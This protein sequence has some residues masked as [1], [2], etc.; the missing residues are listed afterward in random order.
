MAAGVVYGSRYEAYPRPD[1]SSYPYVSK[2]V[3]M[4][5]RVGSI[6]MSLHFDLQDRTR[7]KIYCAAVLTSGN[8]ERVARIIRQDTGVPYIRRI[9]TDANGITELRMDS[10]LRRK[11]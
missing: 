1:S 10:S 3:G 7:R 6:T 11:R 9:E 2:S 4:N 5:I 8:D